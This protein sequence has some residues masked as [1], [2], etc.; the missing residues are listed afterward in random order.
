MLYYI[1]I[2]PVLMSPNRVKL[3]VSKGIIKMQDNRN[4]HH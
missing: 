1:V 2:L 3:L 4:G